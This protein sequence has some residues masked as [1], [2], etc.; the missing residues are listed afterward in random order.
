MIVLNSVGFGGVNRILLFSWG[1]RCF[2]NFLIF[3]IFVIILFLVFNMFKLLFVCIKFLVSF[4]VCNREFSL[5][6]KLFICKWSDFFLIWRIFSIR[7]NKFRFFFFNVDMCF[8]TM[9]LILVV[10]FCVFILIRFVIFWVR[11][12]FF[13]RVLIFVF[14]LVSNFFVMILE[15]FIV[16]WRYMKLCLMWFIIVYLW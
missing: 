12:I 2:F 11:V 4:I 6:R 1:W 3:C 7:R 15:F 10:I 9:F 16:F 5:R 8:F 14:V 13:F